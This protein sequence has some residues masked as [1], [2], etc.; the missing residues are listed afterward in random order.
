MK[1][2][3]QLPFQFIYRNPDIYKVENV[4][5]PASLTAPDI[6]LTLDWAE[7][8]DLMRQVHDA[9]APGNP[10]F[11]VAEIVDLFRRRPGLKAVNG[12]RSRVAV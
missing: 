4:R 1:H 5:A 7:D 10:D 8:L 3:F 6:N 12:H 9:L 11:G 2:E